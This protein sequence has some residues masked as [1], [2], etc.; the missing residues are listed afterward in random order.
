MKCGNRPG[1]ARFNHGSRHLTVPLRPNFMRAM[2]PNVCFVPR[3][4]SV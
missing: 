4:V 3:L 1:D 2:R